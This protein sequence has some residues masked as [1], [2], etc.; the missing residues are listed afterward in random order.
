MATALVVIDVQE[1]MEPLTAHDGAGVVARIASL[2]EGARKSGTKV[3]YVQH[4]GS[5]EPGHPLARDKPGHAIYPAIAPHDVEPTIVKTHCSAFQ[6]TDFEPLLKKMGVDHLV[7]CGMQTEYC[8][9][10]T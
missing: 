7:V 10:T 2:L 8:V 6:E 9:D 5:A 4:D 1:G 3:V